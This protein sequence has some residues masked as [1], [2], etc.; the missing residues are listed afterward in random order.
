MLL[1]AS[2]VINLNH[3]AF[4]ALFIVLL[5]LSWAT[6]SLQANGLNRNGVGAISSAKG[7]TAVTN[8]QD[9][10]AA[11]SVNPAL[12]TEAE[13]PQFWIGLT[14]VAANGEYLSR[15]GNEGS[16]IQNAGLLGE[17]ALLVPLNDRLSLGFSF[18]PDS[19]R[20]ADWMYV[21]EPGGIDGST[22]FGDVRHRSE[23]IAVRLA[24][25]FGFQLTER[26][27]LG[28]SF[29]G[30]Y[31]QNELESPYIFQQNPALAGFKTGLDLD[32]EGWGVN[33]EFGLTF[34]LTDAVTFGLSYRTPTHIDAT[35]TATGDIDAQFDSLGLSGVPSKFRYDAEVNTEL[36]QSLTAG[37]GI[38]L[39]EKTRVDFQIDWI[40]WGGAFDELPIHLT[41]GTNATINSVAG[42]DSVD[43]V[44]PLDWEDV[45][46]TRIGLEHWLKEHMAL[47]AGYS[48]GKSPVS[49]DALLPM[50][51]AISEHTLSLGVGWEFEKCSLNLSYQYDLPATQRAGDSKILSGEYDGS[52][53][54]L[55]SHWVAIS[56]GFRF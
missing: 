15:S 18:I 53:I 11:M 9:G 43:D 42:G 37:L 16:L 24:A 50:T 14:G 36:P 56:A 48:Y 51:A 2:Q 4:S 44:V 30:V 22:S 45:F 21:D 17:A 7:G 29:G 49:S 19:S 1:A 26:L 8:G 35:G 39:T 41:N 54:N 38:Q 27:S 47:R 5:S 32:T 25:G 3:R 12:L 46:V 10:F 33:G 6:S 28:A 23:I 40:D 55:D 31:N 20:V 34:A 52:R 13:E